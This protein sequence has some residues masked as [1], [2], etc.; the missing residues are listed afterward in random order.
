MG[1]T[2][3]RL[4][5]EE[6]PA[7]GASAADRRESP[8]AAS[9]PAD[10]GGAKMRRRAGDLSGESVYVEA[11]DIPGGGTLDLGGEG[12]CLGALDVAGGTIPSDSM[13][14]LSP[15]TLDLGGG[16]CLNGDYC[17]GAT[18]DAD[19]SEEFGRRDERW[20]KRAAQRAARRRRK[21]A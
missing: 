14:A 9:V 17:G 19:R 4:R 6:K 1:E 5:D 20:R 3:S 2:A 8:A 11:R 12:V 21:A 18:I 7:E 15:G 16:V 10:E 13:I